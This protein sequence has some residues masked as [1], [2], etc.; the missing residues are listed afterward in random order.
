MVRIKRISTKTRREESFWADFS[1][2]VFGVVSQRS[3]ISYLRLGKKGTT[4]KAGDAIPQCLS[5][6]ALGKI[7][8]RPP[9]RFPPPNKS[10]SLIDFFSKVI[11]WGIGSINREGRVCFGP[12]CF[13]P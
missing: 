5:L 12:F 13:V 3:H 9:L 6:F 10:G 1:N 11:D 8:I 2:G 7:R 4:G